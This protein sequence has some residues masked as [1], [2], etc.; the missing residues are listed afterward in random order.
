MNVR[1]LYADPVLFWL[2]LSVSLLGLVAIWDAGYARSGVSGSVLPREFVSQSVYLVVAVGAGWLCTFIPRK[3]WNGLAWVGLILGFAALL[4]VRLPEV[5]QSVGGA[6]RWIKV[7]SMTVQ[8]AEFVKLAAIMFL[9]AT[10][11]NHKPWRHP[12]KRL[13]NIGER[14]NR[15]WIP[16]FKRSFPF[17]L[18]LVLAVLVER[19]PDLATA[20][21]VVA[22]S[23]AI[24]SVAGVTRK[25]LVYL[26]LGAVLFVGFAVVEQP[27]RLERFKVHSAR[28]EQQNRLDKGYQTVISETALASGGL[29]GVGLGNGQAKHRLPA[30]TTDFVLTT[31]GEELGLVGVLVI[32]MMLATIVWRMFWLAARSKDVFGRLALVGIGTWIGVQTCTN[33]VM[34]NGSLP[35]IGIPLPF[36][37][38]GGSSLLALWMAV[39]I[40]MSFAAQESEKEV[41]EPEADR[42]GWR[43]RRPRVSRS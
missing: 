24:I 14:I 41:S 30:P 1:R 39:G 22:A 2:C 36:V 4:A 31:V 12:K 26:A 17:L 8:P 40:S 11:A 32:V 9:A 13:K 33:V 7:G 43:D 10:M 19:Q 35:P 27:Y 15:V 28:W 42:Y 23:V 18:V 6:Q 37:S 38:Y 21:V 16:K 3:K 25:S 20:G 5:G 29:F 34:V